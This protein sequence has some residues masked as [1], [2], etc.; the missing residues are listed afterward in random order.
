MLEVTGALAVTLDAL[1]VT[2]GGLVVAVDDVAVGLGALVFGA[3]AE[4]EE[5]LEVFGVLGPSFERIDTSFDVADVC[6]ASPLFPIS[7][8]RPIT[9]AP[10]SSMATAFLSGVHRMDI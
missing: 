10:P 3:L 6:W 9:S 1:E 8:T 5:T 2:L 7:M 4:P